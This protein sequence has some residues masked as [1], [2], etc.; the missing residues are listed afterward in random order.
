MLTGNQII[1]NSTT[2]IVIRKSPHTGKFNTMTLP[3]TKAQYN[4]WQDGSLIQD[5]MP[6]L[7][8]DE[9]EFILTGLTVQD[10]EDIMLG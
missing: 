1:F 4:A 7:T 8:A 3:V 10:W 6:H 9:R 2:A 5:A